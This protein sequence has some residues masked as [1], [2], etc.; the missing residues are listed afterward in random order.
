MTTTRES[1]RF[2]VAENTGLLQQGVA[3]IEALEPEIYQTNEHELFE[4]GIGKHVRH[5][6]DFYGSL[7]AP[8]DGVIDYC[9]RQRDQR[10][11]NDPEYAV[12]RSRAIIEALRRIAEERD[13][14][15]PVTVRVETQTPDGGAIESRSTLVRELDAVAGHTIHHFAL[16]A[17]LARILGATVPEEFG[18]A[19]STLRHRQAEAAGG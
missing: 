17:Q 11:E 13:G 10:I 3:L 18:V 9:A 2:T 8:C 4:S 16:I 1:L 14:A 12:E 15:E 6:L 5:V 19:P 7:V